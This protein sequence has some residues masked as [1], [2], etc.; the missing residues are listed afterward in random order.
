MRIS[1]TVTTASCPTCGHIFSLSNDLWL[2]IIV[3]ATFPIAIP[4]LIAFNILFDRVFLSPLIP[5]IGNPIKIC[6]KCGSKIN[7]GKTER[8]SLSKEEELNYSFKWL[9]RLSYLLGGIVLLSLLG[10]VLGLFDYDYTVLYFLYIS[11]GSAAIITIIAIS[12]RN[13][14]NAIKQKLNSQQELP[15]ERVVVEKISKEDIQSNYDVCGSQLSEAISAVYAMWDFDT[16]NYKENENSEFRSKMYLQVLSP[17]LFLD[18]YY[19]FKSGSYKEV[20]ERIFKVRPFPVIDI[21]VQMGFFIFKTGNNIYILQSI[22]NSND[23]LAKCK[24]KA[25]EILNAEEF[26]DG[27]SKV[28][29]QNVSNRTVCSSD[30]KSDLP[31]TSERF[32]VKPASRCHYC[33]EDLSFMGYE[34][35]SDV[36]CPF[37]NTRTRYKSC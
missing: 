12:Y 36:I 8:R 33:N 15:L 9:F 35:E 30:S 18:N 16:K 6:P 13:K 7:S 34:E 10:F 23:E 31:N 25:L 11:L 28:R 24:A 20:K 2:Y 27:V 4:T 19:L 5:N 22:V 14:L 29:A 17:E 21:L 1:Y 3:L 32:V 26:I 37:C